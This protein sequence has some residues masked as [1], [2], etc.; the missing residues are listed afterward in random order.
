MDELLE[1]TGVEKDNYAN[2]RAIIALSKK[3]AE[4]TS[5]SIVTIPESPE[6]TLKLHGPNL[7]NIDARTMLA[8]LGKCRGVRDIKAVFPN[9]GLNSALYFKV[10]LQ[11]ERRSKFNLI[12]YEPEGKPEKTYAMKQF[13]TIAGSD[14]GMPR[15]LA[16]AIETVA[17]HIISYC[18]PELILRIQYTKGSDACI[19]TFV[20]ARECS[21]SF[22]E[23]LFTWCGQSLLDLQF[24]SVN[25]ES[26]I[27]AILD[28]NPAKIIT[29]PERYDPTIDDDNQDSSNTSK[30]RTRSNN[31]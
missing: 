25:H 8:P 17:S 19:M 18:K 20:G 10:Q 14:H 23:H 16:S 27:I 5:F 6:L 22:V 15:K 12:H 1:K 31:Y 26:H 21:L 29:F 28:T 3:I 4:C 9:S 30:K 2:L 11:K 24:R 7:K 13:K